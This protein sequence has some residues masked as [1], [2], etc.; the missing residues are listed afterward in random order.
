L[1]FKQFYCTV[2]KQTNYISVS[3]TLWMVISFIVKPANEL[4]SIISSLSAF[5]SS[6]Y[7]PC[8][9]KNRPTFKLPN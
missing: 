5:Q 8:Y 9:C 1:V 7:P 3:I 6:I 4:H 2:Y